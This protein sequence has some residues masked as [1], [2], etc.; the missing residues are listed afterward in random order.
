MAPRTVNGK[1]DDHFIVPAVPQFVAAV[2]DEFM[3][4]Y[5]PRRLISFIV[6]CHGAGP[7][8]ELIVVNERHGQTQKRSRYSKFEYELVALQRKKA[9][10]ILLNDTSEHR[11]EEL[12]NLSSHSEKSDQELKELAE[13]WILTERSR[14]DL[15]EPIPDHSIDAYELSFVGNR[16]KDPC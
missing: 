15:P 11:L 3:R 12:L 4:V 7:W 2:A 14:R 10:N 16:L 5:G 1:M 9:A 13:N 8:R 6:R